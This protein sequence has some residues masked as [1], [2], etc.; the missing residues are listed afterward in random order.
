MGEAKTCLQKPVSELAHAEWV[1]ES[2]TKASGKL[3]GV[4]GKSRRDHRVHISQGDRP[5]NRVHIQQF[6]YPVT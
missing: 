3:S 6:L 4:R 2:Q 1:F 5:G